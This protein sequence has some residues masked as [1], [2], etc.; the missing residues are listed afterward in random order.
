MELRPVMQ[1]LLAASPA[2]KACAR[3]AAAYVQ[4]AGYT[5][6]NVATVGLWYAC[7]MP[8]GLGCVLWCNSCCILL[9]YEVTRLINRRAL[10]SLQQ[11][12]PKH[13]DTIL[14]VT[15]FVALAGVPSSTLPVHAV[16]AAT[17]HALWGF[18]HNFDLNRVYCLTPKLSRAEVRVLWL[19][20]L[21]GHALS[22][23]CV[24][25]RCKINA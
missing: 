23:L 16:L 12:I 7:G 15:P 3:T 14:H 2:V 4:A 19:C 5:Q 17:A 24:Y 21:L 22:P 9:S 11:Q 10:R 25:L 20:A 13:A 8:P 6:F 18:W 1:A